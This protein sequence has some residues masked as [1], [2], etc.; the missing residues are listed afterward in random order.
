VS[1]RAAAALAGLAAIVALAAGCGIPTDS[2]PRPLQDVPFG[3]VVPPTTVSADEPTPSGSTYAA[4]L[5]FVSATRLVGVDVDL[6]LAATPQDQARVVLEALSSGPRENLPM[7][8]ALRPSTEMSVTLRGSLATVE[9]DQSV[10]DVVPDEQLF[11]IGQIV[12]SLTRV[13]PIVDVQFTANG[14]PLLVFLPDLSVADGPVKAS[15][16][17]PLLTS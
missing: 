1:R 14:Q 2:S 13:S 17:L 9:L 12:L 10:L 11:A 16:Y 7:R 8:S 4:K 6:P 15:D 5:Y 3:L